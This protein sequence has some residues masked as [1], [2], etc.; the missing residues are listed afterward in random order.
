M[1]SFIAEYWKSNNN[2]IFESHG[3]FNIV[4]NNSNYQPFI[5]LFNNKKELF[6]KIPINKSL[7]YEFNKEDEY[8]LLIKKEIGF[9]FDKNSSV[10]FDIFKEEL[11]K[12]INNQQ[13]IKYYENT[14]KIQYFGDENKNKEWDGKVSEYYNNRKNSL[15]FQGEMEEG[16]YCNGIF[17]NSEGSISIEI[18]NIV[19]NIPNGYIIINIDKNIYKLMYEDLENNE[20]YDIKYFDFVNKLCTD[21]FGKDYMNKLNFL[22]TTS[23]NRDLIVFDEIKKL[24]DEIK[25]LTEQI[26]NKY[27]G[28]F[29]LIKW[30]IGI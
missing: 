5:N 7:N 15:K 29:G 11:N 3:I 23:A 22:S 9:R 20:L 2:G 25:K 17:Y 26:N 19:D 6:L 16:E 30:I 18:N 12:I 4:I 13:T 27:I 21:H 28:I 10:S 24:H 8:D 1:T 14:N